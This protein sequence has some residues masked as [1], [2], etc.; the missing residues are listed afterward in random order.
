MPVLLTLQGD[1]RSIGHLQPQGM[2][3]RFQA[4]LGLELAF[5]KMK[6]RLI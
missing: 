1:M 6:M 3:A 2:L 5:A 4:K